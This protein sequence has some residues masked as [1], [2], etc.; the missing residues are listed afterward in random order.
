[1]SAGAGFLASDQ[2]DF[3]SIADYSDR[4]VSVAVN[5]STLANLNQFNGYSAL[6]RGYPGTPDGIE[7]NLLTVGVRKPVRST[8]CARVQ[9]RRLCCMS[10]FV[11]RC[12]DAR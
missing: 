12:S 11:R 10:V 9:A 8:S 2:I 4:A 1:M 3:S 7:P 5:S 6:T